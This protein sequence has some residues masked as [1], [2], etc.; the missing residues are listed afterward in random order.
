MLNPASAP[1]SAVP[2]PSKTLNG[3]DRRRALSLTSLDSAVRCLR[4]RASVIDTFN[5]SP[6]EPHKENFGRRIAFLDYMIKPIQRIC[7]YPL[8]LDQL[9]PHHS[10]YPELRSDIDVVVE[11]AAQAMRHVATSV[12]EARHRQGIAIQS[13]LILSRFHLPSASIQVHASLQPITYQFLSSLGNCS[14]AGSLDVSQHPAEKPVGTANVKVK[15]FGAFLYPG[16]YLLLV[17]VHNV[18]KYEPRHWFSL[19]EFDLTDLEDDGTLNCLEE[20]SIIYKFF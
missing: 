4:P 13:S 9:K 12:D 18:R 3:D 17:K 1:N 8:L 10:V 11:S 2:T 19:A 20:F 15:Y 5:F 16:G 7:K 14:L 6:V